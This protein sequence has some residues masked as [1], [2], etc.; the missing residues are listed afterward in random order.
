[1]RR[2]LATTAPTFTPA[3]GPALMPD[4]VGLPAREAVR[5]LMAIGL[6]PRL[7]GTGFV[8]KQQPLAGVPLG[9]E[10]VG[11]LELKRMVVSSD[12][13]SEP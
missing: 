1:M 11:S 5:Q 3:G 6:T 4:L 12:S 7:T 2:V 8:L 9:A 13:G 10:A